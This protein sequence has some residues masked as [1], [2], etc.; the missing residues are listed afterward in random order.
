MELGRFQLPDTLLW[1]MSVHIC[2]QTIILSANMKL[3]SPG[4]A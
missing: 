2:K 1:E 3:S 4:L